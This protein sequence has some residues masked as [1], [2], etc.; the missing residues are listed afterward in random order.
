MMNFRTAMVWLLAMG[1]VN[2]A[3]AN[4]TGG[5]VEAGNVQISQ[6]DAQTVNIH[7]STDKGI[8]NWQTF[9]IQAGE[10][11]NFHQPSASSITLNR[12]NAMNGASNIYGNLNAN[13]QVWLIN[14]AGIMFGQGAQV[15][16]G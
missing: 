3:F 15:N 11:T 14:P 13:G 2:P 1:L 6:P 4:P 7:Q 16:V 8:V 12:I 10:T 5:A 9:N